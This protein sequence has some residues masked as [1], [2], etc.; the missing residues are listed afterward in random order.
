MATVGN[1]GAPPPPPG[2]GGGG[3]RGPPGVD[4]GGGGKRAAMAALA[5]SVKKKK[6]KKIPLV[7]GSSHD[8]RYQPIALHTRAQNTAGHYM[9]A[10]KTFGKIT[11]II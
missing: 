5:G 11:T 7:I 8:L 6:K 4:D 3:K 9:T 1:S 2:G 10:S